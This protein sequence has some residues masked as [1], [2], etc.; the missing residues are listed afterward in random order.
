MYLKKKRPEQKEDLIAFAVESGRM[1]HHHPIGYLG[2]VAVA[3]MTSYAFQD[4][5][6]NNWGFKC[7]ADLNLAKEYVKKSNHCVKE[8]MD[9]WHSFTEPFENYLKERNINKE[10]NGD[11]SAVT[12]PA[13]YGVKERDEFYKT[14]T[15][16]KWA[17]ANGLDSLLIAY[18]GLLACNASWTELCHRAMLHGGDNDSTGCIAGAWYGALYGLDAVPPKNYNV[19]IIHTLFF[20][21]IYFFSN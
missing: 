10:N 7:L 12:F 13:K 1:T 15:N 8:N 4:I 9:T 14:I 6:I 17:G 2:C 20:R 18:D 11:A 5:H 19:F 21:Y 3:L 16:S